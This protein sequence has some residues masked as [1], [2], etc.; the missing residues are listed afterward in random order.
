MT[1]QLTLTLPA[2]QVSIGGQAVTG[3]A[4]VVLPVDTAQIISLLQGMGEAPAPAPLPTPPAPV[5]VVEQPVLTA[6][7]PEAVPAAEPEAEESKPVAEQ[8][9]VVAKR[10]G[11]RSKL[12]AMD[13]D[14]LRQAILSAGRAKVASEQL[15]ASVPSIY[16]H[17]KRLGIA[18]PPKADKVEEVAGTSAPRSFPPDT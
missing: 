15:G 3:S 13:D 17:M 6:S 7:K 14:D 10:I 9:K 1:L 12:G 5:V 2:V 4:T 11:S 8:P 18:F 16:A